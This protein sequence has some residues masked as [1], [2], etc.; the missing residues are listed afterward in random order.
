MKPVQIRLGLIPGPLELEEESTSQYLFDITLH[1][2]REVVR[3]FSSLPGVSITSLGG[4]KPKESYYNWGWRWQRSL[5]RL[6]MGMTLLNWLETP[7][8]GGSPLKGECLFEDLRD[9]WQKIHQAFPGAW[10]H[11]E[12]DLEIL[13]PQRLMEKYARTGSPPGRQIVRCL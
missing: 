7:V 2:A 3:V 13:T 11:D 10:L 5:W 6:D 1:P 12:G 9:L 4:S 8:W